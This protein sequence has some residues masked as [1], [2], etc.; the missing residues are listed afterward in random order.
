MVFKNNNFF[1]FEDGFKSILLDNLHPPSI[2][3]EEP[4]IGGVNKVAQDIL[5][6]YINFDPSFLR[7]ELNSVHDHENYIEIILLY[8]LVFVQGALKN[9]SL[10][11]K[12]DLV[13]RKIQLD[14]RY[15][16]YL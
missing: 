7:P 5:S 8:N 13:D 2:I 1:P 16:R 11:T 3:I 4:P 6:Q 15:G 14:E 9:G 12:R 10:L